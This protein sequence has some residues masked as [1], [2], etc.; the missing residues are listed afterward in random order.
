M[1]AEMPCT[2]ARVRFLGSDPVELYYTIPYYTAKR[3][4]NCYGLCLSPMNSVE[5]S[6]NR[7]NNRFQSP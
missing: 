2:S 4:S 3:R 6:D 5:S 7:L 1:L